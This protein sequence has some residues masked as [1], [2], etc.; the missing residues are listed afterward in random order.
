MPDS[1]DEDGITLYVKDDAPV[2]D[3]QPRTGTSLETLH[4]ALSGLRKRRKLGIEPMAH[5]RG[6]AEPL[7]C[8]RSSKG[9][10]H[11]DIITEYD[12]RVKPGIAYSNI[13]MHP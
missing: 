8:G 12:I 5:V 10:L 9:D 1:G 3:S 7:S 6:E 4:I 2:T 13:W 11:S